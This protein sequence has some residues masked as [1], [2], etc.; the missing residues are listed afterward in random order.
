MIIGAGAATFAAG[1]D[2]GVAS[3]V[4]NSGQ[5]IGAALGTALLT[6]IMVASTRRH[7]EAGGPELEA[8][9][10]GYAD[11]SVVGASLVALSAVAVVILM[12]RSAAPARSS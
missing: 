9:V 6:S 12:R 8:A 3:A 2:S 7:A 4:V 10:A 11:A 1:T 5:Q